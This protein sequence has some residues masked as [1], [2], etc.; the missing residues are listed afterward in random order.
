MRFSRYPI[1]KAYELTLR[2]LAVARRAVQRHKDRYPL[3]Q[4]LLNHQT[5]EET[6]ALIANDRETCCP[7]MRDHHR[8]VI[9]TWLWKSLRLSSARGRADG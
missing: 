3:F 9:K 8:Q 5:A 4:E 7:R 2:K 6:L 1:W